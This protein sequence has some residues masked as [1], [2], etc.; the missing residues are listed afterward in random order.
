MVYYNLYIARYSQVDGSFNRSSQWKEKRN[1]N[2][3]VEGKIIVA[4]SIKAM[5][6]YKAT[7][8]KSTAHSDCLARESTCYSIGNLHSVCAIYTKVW[9]MQI[10]SEPSTHI[11]IHV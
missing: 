7:I 2:I 11:H 3:P 9:V 5:D 4:R 1:I 10:R 6:A 8:S